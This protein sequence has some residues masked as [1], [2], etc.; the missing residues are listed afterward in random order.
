M[1]NI[2]IYGA[3]KKTTILSYSLEFHLKPLISG[4]IVI[5]VHIPM[6]REIT[7]LNSKSVAKEGK[8]TPSTPG[9]REVLWQ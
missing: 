8:H 9:S 6:A 4:S 1:W 5:A 2:P 7:W 3:E